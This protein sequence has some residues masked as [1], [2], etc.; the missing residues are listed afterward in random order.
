MLTFLCFPLPNVNS[1]SIE[2]R[3]HPPHAKE[4]SLNIDPR[5]STNKKTAKNLCPAKMAQIDGAASA[6]SMQPFNERPILAVQGMAPA[7]PSGESLTESEPIF[8]DGSE[9]PKEPIP[10]LAPGGLACTLHMSADRS[11]Q[12][13]SSITQ[14]GQNNQIA[15]STRSSAASPSAGPSKDI[16]FASNS[17]FYTYV[18]E[19]KEHGDSRPPP[20]QAPRDCWDHLPAL[21]QNNNQN[22]INWP[23]YLQALGLTPGVYPAIQVK[24][25]K[26]QRGQ[27]GNT[28]KAPSWNYLI[29]ILIAMSPKGK[30]EGWVIHNL[31]MAWCPAVKWKNSSMRHNLTVCDEFRSEPPHQRL[32]WVGEPPKEPTVKE[33]SGKGNES[34]GMGKDAKKSL[35]PNRSTP[36][37][38]GRA[39]QTPPKRQSKSTKPKRVDFESENDFDDDQKLVLGE[40][41]LGLQ[42]S[43]RPQRKII[44]P[45][46]YVDGSRKT[47]DGETQ[48]NGGPGPQTA[49]SREAKKFMLKFNARG[50]TGNPQAAARGLGP[51]T[52]VC[53]EVGESSSDT[54][55]DPTGNLGPR[56]PPRQK[57]RRSSDVTIAEEEAVSSTTSSAPASKALSSTENLAVKRVAHK[58]YK[59]Y[60]PPV[61]AY[62][63]PVSKLPKPS[64]NRP[65]T[66]WVEP[67]VV[68]YVFAATREKACEIVVPGVPAKSVHRNPVRKLKGL[69]KERQLEA[70]R[71][72]TEKYPFAPERHP[73]GPR[74][75]WLSKEERDE[76]MGDF[77]HVPLEYEWF[78]H[79]IVGPLKEGRVRIP[80]SRREERFKLTTEMGEFEGSSVRGALDDEAIAAWEFTNDY[81]KQRL[82]F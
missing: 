43:S 13:S 32:S 81:S 62:I 82:S 1:M 20:R 6:T 78:S 53:R 60:P 40:G 34:S 41:N 8:Q 33:V 80:G 24:G 63:E 36:R 58:R 2:N 38:D 50:K 66:I 35:T 19:W 25:M 7:S 26:G 67:P 10:V 23:P 16:K 75:R 74:H 69:M 44:G 30:L 21:S 55:D 14:M 4:I 77:V 70:R 45:K 54:I 79:P 64:A 51:Q 27:A 39:S 49:A 46:K 12:S 72:G 52:Q 42:T 28:K 37:K 11:T 65:D 59:C 56:T 22:N 31:V 61:P 29:Y 5:S 47:Q 15:P 73:F 71:S 48:D 17:L 9:S 68:P 57:R 3:Q 18:I 76:I